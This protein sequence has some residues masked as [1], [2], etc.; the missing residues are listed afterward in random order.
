[1]RT[2][3]EHLKRIGRRIGRVGTI[4]LMLP[5]LFWVWLAAKKP[6]I[7]VFNVQYLIM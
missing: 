3:E 6:F 7:S 5:I 1:M 2:L 4:I